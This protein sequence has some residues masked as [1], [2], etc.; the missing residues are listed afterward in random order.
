MYYDYRVSEQEIYILA[1]IRTIEY[2]DQLKK[3]TIKAKSVL[4]NILN[5]EKKLIDRLNIFKENYENFY[6]NYKSVL[7]LYSEKNK[8]NKLLDNFEKA[9]YFGQAI[10]QSEEE[11]LKH[12]RPDAYYH[13]EEENIKHQ[14]KYGNKAYKE[15]VFHNRASTNTPKNIIEENIN[16]IN[17]KFYYDYKNEQYLAHKQYLEA[18]EAR[19][20]NDRR[21]AEENFKKLEED[22]KKSKLDL[23]IMIRLRKLNDEISETY[24]PQNC[25]D[26]ALLIDHVKIDQKNRLINETYTTTKFNADTAK[27]HSQFIQYSQLENEKINL[28]V[29]EIKL[30]LRYLKLTR[31]TK[32]I[33]EIVTGR[34]EF[35]QQQIAYIYEQKKKN[36]EE[37]KNKRIDVMSKKVQELEMEIE[38]KD[39]ENEEFKLKYSKLSE[40]VALKEQ[41][42]QLDTD[43][44][45][46]SDD[47]KKGAK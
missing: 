22:T 33:Q 36:L 43:E 1:L 27:D 32:R 5:E 25:I 16:I 17:Q 6:E 47:G 39:R 11:Y 30:K 20:T 19:I 35:D 42:N 24:G 13:Y 37:N 9:N 12:I 34:E 46:F 4:D 18:E 40:E 7:T 45:S 8:T 14:R 26:E 21:N 29:H 28:K 3:Q 38:K 10:N 15:I 31:V 2:R 44:K 41:I 23:D